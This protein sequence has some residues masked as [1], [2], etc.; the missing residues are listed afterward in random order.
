MYWV[1]LAAIVASCFAVSLWWTEWSE[2]KAPPKKIW[3]WDDVPDV[4]QDLWVLRIVAALLVLG[5]GA[6]VWISRDLILGVVLVAIIFVPLWLR[7]S[8]LRNR[9]KRQAARGEE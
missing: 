8:Q 3:E 6:T 9:Q 7:N 4:T 5:I 1:W 2:R